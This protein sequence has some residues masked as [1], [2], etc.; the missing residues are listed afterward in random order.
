MLL[1][2]NLPSSAAKRKDV[3][4]VRANAG[5]AVSFFLHFFSDQKKWAWGSGG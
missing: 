4:S 5:K 3:Y 1:R 2:F